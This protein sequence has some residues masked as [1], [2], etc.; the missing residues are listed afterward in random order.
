MLSRFKKHFV[1]NEEGFTLIE[2]MIVVVIIGILAAVAIPIFSNQ[3]KAAMEASA[4][5]DLRQLSQ[6]ITL[7]KIK[8]NS[9]LITIT[10][11]EFTSSACVGLPTGTD[12]STLPKTNLCW[13]R[14]ALALKRISDAS[15]VNVNG[16]VDPYNRP[17]Y[18]DENEAES[19]NCAKDMV[20]FF[21][22]PN[23]AAS[24]HVNAQTSYVV[25][26]AHQTALCS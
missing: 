14:Y 18:M 8:T 22:Y 26:V 13:T 17:Y 16:L 19:G 7:A 11:S 4:K 21:V 2:L 9:A 3:Q 5:S 23:N 6:A 1:K 25:S 12:Y 24:A 10:G 20:G 15:G